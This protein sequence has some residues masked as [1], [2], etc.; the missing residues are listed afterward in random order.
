MDLSLPEIELPD[1]SG[2]SRKDILDILENSVREDH[3]QLVAAL[4]HNRIEHNV[5]GFTKNIFVKNCDWNT[6]FKISKLVDQLQCDLTISGGG[7]CEYSMDS[8]CQGLDS[9][10]AIWNTKQYQRKFTQ[11]CNFK[12]EASS[13]IGVIDSGCSFS[14]YNELHA[15]QRV[16]MH[17][18]MIDCADE[19]NVMEVDYEDCY[20]RNIDGVTY[21]GHGTGVVDIISNCALPLTKI[22]VANIGGR[23]NGGNVDSAMKKLCYLGVNVMNCSFTVGSNSM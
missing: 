18:K 21:T 12:R 13:K 22:Y 2:K 6:L 7:P 3:E 17:E 20:V 5:T 19:K 15:S 1:F 14:L 16:I 23:F 4:E 10:E 8:P 11:G 9:G